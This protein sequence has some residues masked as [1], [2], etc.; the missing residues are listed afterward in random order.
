M[1]QQL[2]KMYGLILAG[3]FSRRMGQ[4]KALIEYHG[5]P[6]VMHCHDLLSKCCEKVFVSTR[7]GQQ[8]FDLPFLEDLKEY[9][10]IG[11]LGGILSAMQTHRDV[12]WML[13][14][15]DLPFVTSDTLNYL[16]HNQDQSKIATAYKSSTDDLPEPLCAIWQGHALPEVL[17]FYKRNIYCPRKILINSDAFLL[18]LPNSQWLSNINQPEDLSKA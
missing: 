15:C 8:Y 2:R 1:T 18:P 13:L 11:P 14:A 5:K 9:S 12:A 10:N 16:I 4:D 17:E 3:G 6:Q 7:A